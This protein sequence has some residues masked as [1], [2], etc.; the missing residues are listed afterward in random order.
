VKVLADGQ[1]SA[2]VMESNT[3]LGGDNAMT[4]SGFAGIP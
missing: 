4:Y 2:I 1:L 3:D